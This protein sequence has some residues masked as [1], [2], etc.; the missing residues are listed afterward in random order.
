MR[1][2]GLDLATVTGFAFGEKGQKPTAGFWKLPG[3]DDANLDRTMSS[4]EFSIRALVKANG[5][6]RVAIE[7]PLNLAGKLAHGTRCLTMLSG[8]AGAGAYSG[9]ARWIR[10][11]APQTWRKAVLG[12]GFPDKPKEAAL[13]YCARLNWGV[14]SHDAA[15]ACCIMAWAQNHGA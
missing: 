2:M 3:F 14:T 4:L 13:A 7:A 6:E 12:H 9:G 10:R 11:P 8:A 1:C 5:I 15:E